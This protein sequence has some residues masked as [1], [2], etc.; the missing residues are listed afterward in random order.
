MTASVAGIWLQ[1]VNQLIRACE[2][3]LNGNVKDHKPTLLSVVNRL[4][5]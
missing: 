2:F 1:S 3:V 4:I 5:H